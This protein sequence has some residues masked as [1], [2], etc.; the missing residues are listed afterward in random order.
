MQR[1]EARR[2]VGGS[3]RRFYCRPEEKNLKSHGNIQRL[4]QRIVVLLCQDT[5]QRWL[6]NTG[7]VE[8][9]AECGYIRELHSEN[10]APDATWNIAP[11]V[12]ISICNVLTDVTVRTGKE[13]RRDLS[14]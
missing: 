14:I 12:R 2:N 9:E 8:R 13:F 3:P 7:N 4:Q 5:A 1:G 10:K 6:A 11:Q